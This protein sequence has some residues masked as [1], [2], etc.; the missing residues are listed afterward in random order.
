MYI[1][2][3]IYYIKLLAI[4]II[5]ETYINTSVNL[6]QWLKTKYNIEK[7]FVFMSLIILENSNFIVKKDLFFFK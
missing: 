2:K 3:Y 7:Q 5:S 6:Y 4:Y 1:V